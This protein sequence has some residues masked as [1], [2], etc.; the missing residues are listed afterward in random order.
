MARLECLAMYVSILPMLIEALIMAKQNQQQTRRQRAK[1]RENTAWQW[2]KSFFVAK[3]ELY[4]SQVEKFST[5]TSA[6]TSATSTFMLT[7]EVMPIAM[8][9]LTVIAAAP[10]LNF[11]VP[12]IL[13]SPYF[14][15]PA[16]ISVSAMVGYM[17]Y[18]ELIERA[19]LDRQ[20]HQNQLINE[21]LEK[22]VASLEKA[23]TS[24]QCAWDQHSKQCENK[25]RTF[26]TRRV[27]KQ[28][29][30]KETSLRPLKR[31]CH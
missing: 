6:A 19:K 10:L 26:S 15:I 13:F 31:K 30:V 11:L 23:L 2:V 27:K 7:I 18:Q 29:P 5:Y 14:Y 16:I 9:I 3:W 28:P 12:E 25:H 17:K 8:S 4:Q 21:K 24:T 20:I 22:T 1:N